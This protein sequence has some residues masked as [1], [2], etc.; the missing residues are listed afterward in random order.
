MSAIQLQLKWTNIS[1]AVWS[2]SGRLFQRVGATQWNDLAPKQFFCLRQMMH[3]LNVHAHYTYD[4][5]PPHPPIP[6][7][8]NVGLTKTG[9]IP[10]V[11]RGNSGSTTLSKQVSPGKPTQ[12]PHEKQIAKTVQKGRQADSA[13]ELQRCWTVHGDV[14]VC[15][16]C[17]DWWRNET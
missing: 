4:P 14:K 6:P 2:A 15:V 7:L 5:H 16:R 8:P 13:P 11:F 12:V 9:D 3:Y 17:S 1:S 10:S